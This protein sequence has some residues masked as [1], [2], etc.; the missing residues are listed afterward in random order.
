MQ[1]SVKKHYSSPM[2]KLTINVI[3][4]KYDTDFSM[5]KDQAKRSRSTH[6][7]NERA[8]KELLATT[9]QVGSMRA[10]GRTKKKKKPSGHAPNPSKLHAKKNFS[11]DIYN[12]NEH[13]TLLF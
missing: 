9:I 1:N 5:H 13:G 4:Q 12:V 2:G 8:N 11:K 3:T 10:R 6:F 7:A